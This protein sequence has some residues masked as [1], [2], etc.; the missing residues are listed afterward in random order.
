QLFGRRACRRLLLRSLRVV[1]GLHHESR[2]LLRSTQLLLLRDGSAKDH[3]LKVRKPQHRSQEQ[4]LCRQ[5]TLSQELLFGRSCPSL[6]WRQLRAE[7][8]AHPP[9][10]RSLRPRQPCLSASILSALGKKR[11]DRTLIHSG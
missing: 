8:S 2:P 7:S 5:R 4:S 3:I 10:D 9:V 6:G 1:R 11:E